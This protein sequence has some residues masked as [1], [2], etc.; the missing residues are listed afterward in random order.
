MISYRFTAYYFTIEV[1]T[2]SILATSLMVDTSSGQS[3]FQKIVT[4][5]TAVI[6]SCRKR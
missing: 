2:H 3:S 5:M 4:R 1:E 6:V